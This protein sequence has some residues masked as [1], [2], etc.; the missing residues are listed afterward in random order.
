MDYAVS[1]QQVEKRYNNKIAVDNLSFQIEQGTVTALLGPNGAGKTT[2]ISMMLGLIHPTSGVVRVLG[3]DPIDSKNR[4]NI[5]VMLQEVGLLAN[6]SVKEMIN[7]FRSFYPNPLPTST[8][9]ELANLEKEAKKEVVKL[10]GGQKRRLHFALAMSGNPKVLFLDEPTTGM[11]LASRKSFWNNL[12]DF[13]KKRDG[14]IILTTHYLEEADS[15][16]DRI[17]LIGNGKKIA[18]GTPS[19]LKGMSGDRYVSFVM[20]SDIS[21]E[22]FKALPLVEEVERRGN[23]IK[24]RTKKPDAV[25]KEMIEQKFKVEDFEVSNGGLEDVFLELT[26][27]LKESEL[28]S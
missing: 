1:F 12:H 28:C 8:L 13:T 10:S 7:Q 22:Q 16:A 24:I 26:D 20:R 23:R 6:M 3:K 11:D 9:L 18:D 2:S 5:G 19:E 4:V 14:S 15:I 17:I 21:D 27:N 25:L